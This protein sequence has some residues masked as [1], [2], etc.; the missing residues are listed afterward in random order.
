M[1][2]SAARSLSI[3]TLK[4]CSA[5]AASAQ[6]ATLLATEGNLPPNMISRV[7]HA[8]NFAVRDLRSC[9][10][11]IRTVRHAQVLNRNLTTTT[12]ALICQLHS[13]RAIIVRLFQQHAIVRES[14]AVSS[15]FFSR[16]CLLEIGTC[17]R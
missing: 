1:E 15:N 3:A 14:V 16:T 9:A 10:L 12:T 4:P 7:Q 8:P 2:S 17:V 13:P 6:S 11:A 5:D